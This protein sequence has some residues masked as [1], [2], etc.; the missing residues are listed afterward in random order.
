MTLT[1][2][3]QY[4][5]AHE[6]YFPNA[7]SALGSASSA[8]DHIPRPSND[9]DIP[10]VHL[11][12]GC[13]IQQG[14]TSFCRASLGVQLMPHSLHAP[15]APEASGSC[16]EAQQIVAPDHQMVVTTS[17]GQVFAVSMTDAEAQSSQFKA[18]CSPVELERAKWVSS[19]SASGALQLGP[20]AVDDC[21][22]E[23]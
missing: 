21:I 19:V 18:K 5:A 6:L 2:S 22:L 17:D 3:H 23:T 8:D 4:L 11:K 13:N 14:A 12:A 10:G 9:D 7:D 20:V 15:A 1:I 16:S